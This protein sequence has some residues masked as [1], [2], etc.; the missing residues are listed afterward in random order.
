MVDGRSS[1]FV[2][3]E[4]SSAS[5]VSHTSREA[6]RMMSTLSRSKN[7]F[8]AVLTRPATSTPWIRSV[9]SCASAR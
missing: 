2:V 4:G 7:T 6:A 3:H 9:R 1:R 8:E 5:N